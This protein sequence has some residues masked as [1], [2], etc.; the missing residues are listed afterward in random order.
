[1]IIAVTGELVRGPSLGEEIILKQMLDNGK[2]S[3]TLYNPQIFFCF[4]CWEI[5]S[6]ALGQ[7]YHMEVRLGH[8]VIYTRA[9]KGLVSYE[10]TVKGGVGLGVP[11]WDVR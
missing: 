4:C 1:M 7:G 11:Y 8:T 2:H 9:A 6:L 10:R 3:G 5:Y